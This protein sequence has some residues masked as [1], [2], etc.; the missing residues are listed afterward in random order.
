M[1][2]LKFN[3]TDKT[4]VFQVSPSHTVTVEFEF[5]LVKLSSE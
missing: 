5:A 1:L 3:Q 2:S 4:Y